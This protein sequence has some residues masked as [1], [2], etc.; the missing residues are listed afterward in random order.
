MKKNSGIII[1]F[2]LAAIMAACEKDP[3]LSQLDEDNLVVT[4]YDET[5]DFQSLNTYFIPDSI[6]FIGDSNQVQYL[7][8]LEASLLLDTYCRNLEQRGYTRTRDKESADIGLQLTYIANTQHFI[9]YASIPYSWWVHSGYWS[10]YY[11]GN[12]GFWYY[13]FPVHFN[14]STGSLLMDMINLEAEKGEDKVLPVIWHNYITGLLYDSETINMALAARGVCQA[15]NQS[16][17][18]TKNR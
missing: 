1:G 4:N 17:Y 16:E 18:L 11:W 5:V 7:D 3:D 14:L 15:F 10:P 8:S 9:G 2:F 12:W 6:L 13:P